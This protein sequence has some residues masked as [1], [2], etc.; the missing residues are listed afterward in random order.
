MAKRRNRSNTPRHK[1]LNRS[2]RLDAAKH[3]IPKYEGKHLVK[4][5]SKHFGVDKLCAVKEL[6]I[7][8]YP[9]K[10]SYKKQ[11]QESIHLNQRNVGL[12]HNETE[13]EESNETFAY[14]AG[15]TPGGAPYGI[16]WEELDENE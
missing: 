15:Y 8:G 2:S 9:I 7:L 12:Q 5:Y 11:L 1:R 6:E 13:D 3:W 4:G 16:T 14:I 10:P